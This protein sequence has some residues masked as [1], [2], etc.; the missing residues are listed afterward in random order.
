[1][2]ILLAKRRDFTKVFFNEFGD[3]TKVAIIQM[4]I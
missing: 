4:K 2:N 3:V 1:M